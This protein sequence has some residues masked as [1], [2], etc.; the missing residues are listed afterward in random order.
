MP[1]GTDTPAPVDPRDAIIADLQAKLTASQTPQDTPAPVDPRDA[2]IADLQEQFKALQSSTPVASLQQAAT[3][4]MDQVEADAKSDAST[5]ATD[6]KDDAESEFTHYIHL[7][8]GRIMKLVGSVTHWF[9][10][11][12]PDA[13]PVPVIGVYTK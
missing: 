8:D 13:R 5:V 3:P 11:D 1:M 9:D 2:I 4:V 7:A 10:S 6:V 12:A